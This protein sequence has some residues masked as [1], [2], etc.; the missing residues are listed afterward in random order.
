M[1]VCSKCKIEKELSEYHKRSNR[2]CGVRSICKQC[3]KNDYPKT[4]KRRE[5]YT[6]NYDLFKS[7]KITTEQ[8]NQ[9]LEKQNNRCAICF[10]TAK[11]KNQNFKLNLCVDHDHKTG[12]IRG[13]LCDGCN[14]ALGMFKD[15]VE[16]L[17]NAMNY[18]KQF[19]KNE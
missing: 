9:K 1:K 8:Y 5:G 18:L 15:S 13:L 17:N 14:R 6:R 3:Y 11:E 16:I 2:P 4:M 12:E 19:Q 7:Y 10:K